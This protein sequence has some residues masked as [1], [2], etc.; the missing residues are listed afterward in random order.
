MLFLIL[1]YKFYYKFTRVDME[2]IRYKNILFEFY[3]TPSYF[4]III[5]IMTRIFTILFCPGVRS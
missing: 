1:K 4:I 5:I 2:I 3:I